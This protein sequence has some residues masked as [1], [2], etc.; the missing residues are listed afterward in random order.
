MRNMVTYSPVAGNNTEKTNSLTVKGLGVGVGFPSRTTKKINPCNSMSYEDFFCSVN[1]VWK[2]AILP[3]GKSP[4][5]LMPQITH[6]VG[7]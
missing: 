5:T 2:F 3:F 1:N 4:A 7:T 6:A